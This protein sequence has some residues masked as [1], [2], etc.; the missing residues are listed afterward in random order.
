[1]AVVCHAF[2]KETSIRV[3]PNKV[4]SLSA[5]FNMICNGCVAFQD[6]SREKNAFQ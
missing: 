6:K 2:L 3:L 5:T 4:K 1:M